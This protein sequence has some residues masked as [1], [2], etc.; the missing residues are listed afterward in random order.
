[1]RGFLVAF[2]LLTIPAHAAPGPTRSIARVKPVSS[3]AERCEIVEYG[4]YRP[5]VAPV[6]FTDSTSV[7]GERFEIDEVEFTRQT[8]AIP[9]ELGKGFGIRYRLRGLPKGRPVDVRWRVVFPR[10]G[11]R[12]ASSWEHGLREST[13]DGTLLHHLLYDFHYTWEMVP[14]TWTFEVAVD[15]APACSFAFQVR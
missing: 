5:S 3:A 12:G 4:L 1:M 9:L 13:A 2:A 7:T 8:K 14:G 15:G 10:P 11:I 6:R